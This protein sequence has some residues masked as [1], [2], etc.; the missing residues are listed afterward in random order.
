MI[1][2]ELDS[3]GH[4]EADDDEGREDEGQDGCIHV[5]PKVLSILRWDAV[6]GG[7]GKV[8]R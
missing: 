5:V 4:I 3:Y 1:S 7:V 6:E 8:G 2:P